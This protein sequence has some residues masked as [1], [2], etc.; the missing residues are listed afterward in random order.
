MDFKSFFP[1]NGL[2]HWLVGSAPTPFG[3]NRWTSEQ[4]ATRFSEQQNFYMNDFT[5][6]CHVVTEYSPKHPQHPW[7]V[8]CEGN[9]RR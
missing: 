9:D 7:R 4:E 3:E 6:S 2:W 8:L 1:H 5:I